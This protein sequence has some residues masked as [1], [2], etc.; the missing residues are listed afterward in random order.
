MSVLQDPGRL[1]HPGTQPQISLPHLK[2]RA[3]ASQLSTVVEG[4]PLQPLLIDSTA[5]NQKPEDKRYLCAYKYSPGVLL[6][7]HPR[8][9]LE[10]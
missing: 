10:P 3:L 1:G 5:S 7:P 8:E 2:V 4:P 9:T 6:I